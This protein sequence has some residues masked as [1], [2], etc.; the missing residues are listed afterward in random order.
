MEASLCLCF[1][2]LEYPHTRNPPWFCPLPAPSSPLPF[3][4]FPFLLWKPSLTSATRASELL[5]YDTHGLKYFRRACA[6]LSTTGYALFKQSLPRIASNAEIFIS[7]RGTKPNPKHHTKD[8]LMSVLRALGSVGTLACWGFFCFVLI[9]S[10]LFP[11]A[12]CFH[13]FL[14]CLF[15]DVGNCFVLIC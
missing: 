6:V 10:C 12:L 11:F 4:P 1:S 5:A 7:C 9:S 2:T 13:L 15:I 3:S 14:S 8:I